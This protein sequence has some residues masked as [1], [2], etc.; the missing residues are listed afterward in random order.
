MSILVVG[1]GDA[2]F[3]ADLYLDGFTNSLNIDYSDVVIKKQ[4]ARFLWLQN[5]FLVMDCLSMDNINNNYFGKV[6]DL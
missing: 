1:C 5:Q 6:F 2:P 4:K 3:S